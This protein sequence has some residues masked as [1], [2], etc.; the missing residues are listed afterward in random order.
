M[1]L[2]IALIVVGAALTVLA[3]NGYEHLASVGS[4]IFIFGGLGAVAK[5]ISESDIIAIPTA[6]I[7]TFP[8]FFACRWLLIKIFDN[9]DGDTYELESKVRGKM[10]TVSHAFDVMDMGRIVLDRPIDEVEEFEACSS[11]HM[12]VGTRV[13]VTG[14][15]VKRLTVIPIS[16]EL[17]QTAPASS[18]GL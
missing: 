2:Y 16:H 14:V 3:F 5:L 8:V 13:K 9:L 17:D 4:T 1:T 18:S 11:S 6:L 7:L 10:G 15:G 12:P